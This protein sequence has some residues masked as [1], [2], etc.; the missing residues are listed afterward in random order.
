MVGGGCVLKLSIDQCLS[1]RSAACKCR[2]LQ[3]VWLQRMQQAAP[4][5]SDSQRAA[6]PAAELGATALTA[7]ASAQL[8]P[9]AVN[10]A[11]VNHTEQPA[12]KGRVIVVTGPTG[13]GKTEASLLL[14]ERLNGEVV[15]ADS[16]QVYRGLDVGS[17]KLPVEQRRGALQWPAHHAGFAMSPHAHF[18]A[19][20]SLHTPSLASD[21][22]QHGAS[23][24]AG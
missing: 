1:S 7:G 23:G 3:Q 10:L 22:P 11:G 5:R 12:Q 21:A 2:H 16:V 20:S 15:S 4:T 9:R 18:A 8:S 13:V 24:H 17:D 19:I 6:P 14:A